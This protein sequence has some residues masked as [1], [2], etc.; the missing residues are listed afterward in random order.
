MRLPVQQTWKYYPQYLSE[1]MTLTTDSVYQSYRTCEPGVHQLTVPCCCLIYVQIQV[2][3]HVY[4]YRKH[5]NV[6]TIA[7]LIHP[8]LCGPKISFVCP[9]CVARAKFPNIRLFTLEP[10]FYVR[11]SLQGDVDML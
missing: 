5:R 8:V 2:I 1:D 10:S 9:K 7:D 11:K 6:S 4:V 3:I